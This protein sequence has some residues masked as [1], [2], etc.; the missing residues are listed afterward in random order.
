M[1]PA[2]IG[3]LYQDGTSV[4]SRGPAPT[5]SPGTRCTWSST[6][7]AKRSDKPSVESDG[8]VDFFVYYAYSKPAALAG[9]G[10]VGT[11]GMNKDP[12]QYYYFPGQRRVRRLPSYTFDTPLIASRTSTWSMRRPGSG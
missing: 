5:T 11:I 7:R 4:I 10:F 8:G 9:Q 2:G 12:E 1:R 3:A 6:G